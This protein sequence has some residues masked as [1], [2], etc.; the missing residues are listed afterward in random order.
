MNRYFV[1]PRQRRMSEPT[2]FERITDIG[3]FLTMRTGTCT[4]RWEGRMRAAEQRALFGRFFGKGTL[5]IDGATERIQHC[6]TRCFGLD[7]EFTADLRW[8][9]I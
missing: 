5:T 8:A 1:A 2:R 4:G 7:Y 6:V 3:L 9:D